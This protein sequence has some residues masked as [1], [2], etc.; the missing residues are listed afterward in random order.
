M[1]ANCYYSPDSMKSSL[2]FSTVAAVVCFAPGAFAER[3]SMK[4]ALSPSEVEQRAKTVSVE[5]K[6]DLP[7]GENRSGSGVIIHRQGDL[8]TV[9]TNRHVVCK[10]RL[11]RC[12]NTDVHA[13]YRL[14]TA[15]AQI[16]Q[17]ARSN[18]KL[19]SDH[20]GGFL[21]LVIVQFRSSRTYAVAQ[22]A[23]PGSLKVEDVIHTAGFPT[24][25]GWLFGT[26]KVQAVVNRRLVGDSGGYTVIYDAE[27]LP[28]MSGGGAF[29]S[30]G[31]L[32][33]IHGQGDK[34]TKNTVAEAEPSNQLQHAIQSKIGYNRGIPIR[35]VVQGLRDSGISLDRSQ[36]PNIA[37][38]EDAAAT[39]ADEFFIAGFNKLVDPGENFQAGRKEA[40]TLFDQ[41]IG[42]NPRYTIA[43]F[44]RAIT[45]DKLNDF[46][47]A[48]ADYSQSIILNPEGAI[49]ISCYYNRGV[50]KHRKLNDPQGALADY[51]QVITLNPEFASSYNNRGILKYEKLNDPQGALADFSKAI[52]LNPKSANAYY[53]RGILRYEK[54]NDPEGALADFNQAIALNPKFAPAYGNRGNLKRE[55]NDPQGALADYNQVI[56]LNPED[57]L[58]YFNRGLLKQSQLSDPQGALVDY[59][60]SIT[61]NPKFAD[62]YNNR[63][64]L[65]D[66]LNNTKGA[67]ADYNQAI[68]FNPEF[69]SAYFNRGNLKYQK[70]NDPQGALADYNKAI[71]L[72]PQDARAYNNRGSL[73]DEL[74]D[75]TG[76]LA[77]YDK[78]ISINSQYAGAYNNRGSLKYQK[79]NDPQGAL[80]DYN[81]AISL[82]PQD[83]LA[84]RNRGILKAMAF[85]DRPGA[86]A[87][88]RTSARLSRTQGQTQNLQIVLEGLRQ[89]GVTETP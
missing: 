32:V 70:L 53:S 72:D 12:T 19:L 44:L 56:F 14:K 48:I 80:A 27:T 42:L 3:F 17:V 28:G 68:Y 63:G 29:D 9:I 20:K 46:Q 33:A 34:F 16:Y 25:Q 49:A 79:L 82:D 69:A 1:V 84:Y 8:Y 4:M 11:E 21:D 10:V 24:G 71:S 89:L 36:P 57:S 59:N 81:K 74:N 43:Y 62:A 85:N 60:Q 51:N 78:A 87:D 18:T 77:D 41:A 5:I 15:D 23:E 40:V 37:V 2:L 22:V 66:N 6:I 7:N 30:N 55:L 65:K 75:T 54:L 45:K 50:L 52:A 39:T 76:S 47:G 67:L 31:R 86:I 88:L 58:A 13:S 26:G 35:W 61:L 38:G 64:S 73:K 83:V